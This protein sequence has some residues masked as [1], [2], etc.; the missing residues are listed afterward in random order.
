MAK[1]KAENKSDL[2][3]KI[4]S[5]CKR[6]GFVFPGSEIYGGLQGFYD[7][8][9][10]GVEMKNNLKRLWWDWMTREHDNIVGIDGAII[11]NPKV[12]EASGHLK[13]FVDPLVECKKCHHRFKADDINAECPDCGGNLTEPKVF[14]ILVPTQ[15]GVIEEEK[16]SAYLRGEACQTIYLDY[17]SVLDTTRLKIPFGI[18]QIGKAF[19]NEVTPGNF[20]FRQREFEQWDLQWFCRP[21]E[22]EKWFEY[23]KS[24]RMAWY[25][26]IF[27][28]PENLGF[29]Q[30]EK[31][32]HYA[33]KAFDIEYTASPVG[34]EMEGIHWRGDWD[35]SRHA[36][37]SGQDLSYADLETGEKFIPN[38]V[39]T[40]GGV[41]RAFLFLLLD[42]YCEEKDPAKDGASRVVLKLNPK[43]AP[44]KIAVFPLLANKPELVKMAKDIYDSLKTQFMAA[45]DD[46][47]NIGKRYY[48]QDEI[49]TPFCVT[50]DFDSLEDKKVTVRERDSMKQER[51]EIN[52]LAE[53]IKKQLN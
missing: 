50:V 22:M 7:F 28:H 32:A 44:Y 34:K 51:V 13:N 20:L 33:K 43:I 36:E 17:K 35:L 4:V 53:Y 9:P 49:G 31:L 18:C 6:R 26:S 21:E 14:N 15:L 5:L 19:R 10:L 30:H 37:F 25:K 8:G 45:W 1:P 16:T 48:A 27:T 11:T 38:I 52:E 39:E 23:W 2:M 41:D 24:E 46:R 40:S 12:W 3:E 47:G 42:A 29:Y